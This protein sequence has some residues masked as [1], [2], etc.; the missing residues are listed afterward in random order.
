[1]CTVLALHFRDTAWRCN[2]LFVVVK[3]IW[4][5][6]NAATN[7]GTEFCNDGDVAFA[8]FLGRR[9]IVYEME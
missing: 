1:M 7:F 9:I 3:L 8:A 5:V 2:K 6:E 4:G